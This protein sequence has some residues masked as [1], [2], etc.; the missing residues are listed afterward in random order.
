MVAVAD[1]QSEVALH[2]LAF[3]FSLK[4]TIIC[5]I[6][7]LFAVLSVGD[8][9]LA[10][11]FLGGIV[12]AGVC[13]A[14]AGRHDEDKSHELYSHA[15]L[16]GHL[17]LVALYLPDWWSCERR[18]DVPIP[19][20]ALARHA[21]YLFSVH[22]AVAPPFHRA[23]H[24]VLGLASVLYSAAIALRGLPLVAFGGSSP[25]SDVTGVCLAVGHMVPE[26][27][28]A[29]LAAWG[30]SAE[31]RG[32]LKAAGMLLAQF[33]ATELIGMLIQDTMRSVFSA[34]VRF[35]AESERR[36]RPLR[37]EGDSPGA[38]SAA[39][40]GLSGL[41]LLE[42]S[43]R[44]DVHPVSL[45]F[46]DERLEAEFRTAQFAKSF[47]ACIVSNCITMLGFAFLIPLS[48]LGFFNDHAPVIST[49]AC[50]AIFYSGSCACRW[51]VEFRTE[52]MERALTLY[53]RAINLHM[54]LSLNLWVCLNN[55]WPL[56]EVGA[57][58]TMYLAMIWSVY[59]FVIRSFHLH[60]MD[61]LFHVFIIVVFHATCPRFSV[62]PE[63]RSLMWSAILFGELMGHAYELLVRR[64]FFTRR[65]RDF[66]VLD[67]VANYESG[68]QRRLDKVGSR[69]R[70][71]EH[72]RGD[73]GEA[74]AADVLAETKPKVTT[75]R[76]DASVKA[77]SPATPT[78][79]A[80][81]SHRAARLNDL[82]AS[83]CTTAQLSQDGSAP[84]SALASPAEVTMRAATGGGTLADGTGG[85][86]VSSIK[87][88]KPTLAT[89]QTALNA[90]VASPFSAGANVTPF[91]SVQN[92]SPFSRAAPAAAAAAAAQAGAEAP[93][94]KPPPSGLSPSQ[95]STLPQL[96]PF[97]AGGGGGATSVGTSP[98]LGDGLSS[99]GYSPQLS[100]PPTPFLRSA[101][102]EAEDDESFGKRRVEKK[103][104]PSLT[105]EMP[106]RNAQVSE[107][108]P[109]AHTALPV[110]WLFLWCRDR[111]LEGWVCAKMFHE[112]FA[113]QM[114]MMCI[115]LACMLACMLSD[116]NVAVV[117]I[118][119][120]L[121]LIPIR[122]WL[123]Y[124][125]DRAHAQ[126]LGCRVT[127]AMDIF[128][129]LLGF[130]A[131]L[132]FP[133]HDIQALKEMN[134][135]AISNP[136]IMKLESAHI[137]TMG[138]PPWV[139][140]LLVVSAFVTITNRSMNLPLSSRN[141]LL[142]RSVLFVAR[143]IAEWRVVGV[144]MRQ[145]LM[146]LAST[147]GGVVFGHLLELQQRTNVLTLTKLSQD[148]LAT[149]H[150]ATTEE[151]ALIAQA[152]AG[153][154]LP[155]VIL[156]A[157]IDLVD[158]QIRQVLG[159]GQFGVVNRAV[160]LHHDPGVGKMRE[161]GLPHERKGCQVAVK[162]AHRNRLSA[163]FLETY[164]RTAE[165][166]L[167]LPHHDNVVHLIGIAWSF[168]A[169]RVSCVFE[170][171][172]SGSLAEALGATSR[173]WPMETK[174]NIAAGLANGLAFLHAQHPPVIHRDV[175]P[176]N[177]LFDD[178]DALT[179]KIA[180]F[181]ASR[182]EQRND[183]T[184]D[185]STPLFSA[186]EQLA[187]R[188]YS[189]SVDV[190][191]YGCCV[192]CLFCNVQ[193]PYEAGSEANA[194]AR[195][196]EDFLKRVER[197]QLRPTLDAAQAPGDAVAIVDTCCRRSDERP[198]AT[199]LVGMLQMEKAVKVG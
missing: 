156:Q 165:L 20:P 61:R 193:S 112:N 103:A 174:R 98:K 166:E 182:L 26:L 121:L 49:V 108:M 83:T 128:N 60:P 85:S 19:A 7:R 131:T 59:I 16:L 37:A 173:G 33:V 199:A 133:L 21:L 3:R 8:L 38:A 82:I 22:V 39:D 80:N 62:I 137:Y 2:S 184:A 195:A 197:G 36:R 29:V 13:L 119:Q 46:F 176:A 40:S 180:D 77:G 91:S 142:L 56:V 185:T 172:A 81:A 24:V 35:G 167:S 47:W 18:V 161:Q 87:Q 141:V 58:P 43:F 160:L 76:F 158:L 104:G 149:S 44:S 144:L 72:T 148:L 17:A 117:T 53:G 159:A 168:D 171:C 143:F 74:A 135:N 110:H 41:D 71:P 164:I 113:L 150:P 92:A 78:S 122:C 106:K 153:S 32:R 34:G 118:G 68:R 15:V 67:S 102:S 11:L 95:S 66:D 151:K 94:T 152:F 145:P 63:Q 116:P 54:I 101:S 126:R 162:T 86:P 25:N 125:P 175:K 73:V 111:D 115:H 70:R 177:I 107:Q 5:M 189:V 89:M 196:G 9:P 75:I 170:L 157:R 123:H 154:R 69:A 130:T 51:Y 10:A 109:M 163:R 55:F 48:Y 14:A 93:P 90:P 45:S 50:A 192:A 52:S 84:S 12:I 100:S 124:V 155:R 169:A 64:W 190:W 179:P 57:Q 96:T 191:A 88:R 183:M 27:Q 28:T 99:S 140:F 1:P 136:I 186:P 42:A 129:G 105:L 114:A 147:I 31:H 188:P 127:T 6:V 97:G 132:V 65:Q 198:A 134:V 23:V 194:E 178:P 187:R 79:G 4:P 181:G 120:L 138:G 139:P 146:I 30:G